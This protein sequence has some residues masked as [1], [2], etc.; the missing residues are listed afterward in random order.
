MEKQ[1][2]LVFVLTYLSYAAVHAARKSFSNA[3]SELNTAFGM[4][5]ELAGA[6]DSFFM[7]IYA[8]SLILGGALGDRLSPTR[9]LFIGLI[10]SSL[11][12]TVFGYLCIS[13]SPAYLLFPI[14]A[15]SA[16]FQSLCWPA[17]I[18][19]IGGWF[20]AGGMVFG[21]WTSNTAVGN[22]LGSLSAAYVL[23]SSEDVKSGVLGVFLLPAV[24]MLFLGLVSAVLMSDPLRYSRLSDGPVI[25]SISFRSCLKLPGILEF[26]TTYAAVK[27]VTYAMFFWLPFYLTQVRGFS[28]ANADA[29]SALF[30]VGQVFGA[31]LCGILADRSGRMA[32]TC[33]LFALLAAPFLLSVSFI[34]SFTLAGICIL[35]SG[36]LLGGVSGLVGS[37]VC[38]SLS[39]EATGTVVGIVDGAGSLGAAVTQAALP[40]LASRLGWDFLFPEM[41]V[42]SVLAAFCL[43]NPMRTEL[44]R[45]FSD[46]GLNFFTCSYFACFFFAFL[47]ALQSRVYRVPSW[48]RRLAK[49]RMSLLSFT[50]PAAPTAHACSRPGRSSSRPKWK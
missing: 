6:L 28:S 15:V 14:V 21:L 34:G 50:L 4:S 48:M 5:P 25:P 32:G 20:G 24:A 42:L 49:G 17:S 47:H 45:P 10:G 2:W 39:P 1:R 30:D 23:K 26:S 13:G 9:L 11:S 8:G 3:K 31:P 41:A 33:A 18:K 7:L 43:K 36:V 29:A 27:G 22:I 46:F 35:I 19:L 12:Q 37:A 38:A 40:A 44:V 16:S